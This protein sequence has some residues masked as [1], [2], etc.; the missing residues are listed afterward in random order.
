MLTGPSSLLLIVVTLAAAW[1]GV[2]A[3]FGDQSHVFMSC[4]HNC[5]FGNCS[6]DSDLSR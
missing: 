5:F 6:T 1:T 3:S 2:G 4:I